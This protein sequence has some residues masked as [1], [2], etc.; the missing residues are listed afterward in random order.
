MRTCLDYSKISE[1]VK[2]VHAPKKY[3]PL[4]CTTADIITPGVHVERVLLRT[5]AHIILLTLTLNGNY[6]I[7][8]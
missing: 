1:H 6:I 7:S 5:I 2:L 8:H 3:H 4:R